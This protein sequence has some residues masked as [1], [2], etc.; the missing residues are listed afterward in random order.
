[1]QS[2]GPVSEMLKMIP[3]TGN[4]SKM[5]LDDRQLKWIDAIINSMTSVELKNPDI[6]DGSRRK[7]IALGSGR[8]VQEVN[9]LLK[10]FMQMRVM[11]KKIGKKGGMKIPFQIK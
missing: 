3:G 11:M 7:R 4:L 10:Q 1:M 6:I 9:Q 2:M 5:N 8:T